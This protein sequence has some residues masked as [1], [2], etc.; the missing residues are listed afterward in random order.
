V[1][2]INISS[3]SLFLSNFINKSIGYENDIVI[4]DTKK[5]VN[6]SSDFIHPVHFTVVAEY[7]TLDLFCEHIQ[8]SRDDFTDKN[9]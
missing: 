3:D 4:Y 1:R 8:V 5:N 2:Y 9:L 7:G 6:G